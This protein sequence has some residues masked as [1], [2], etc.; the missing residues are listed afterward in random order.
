VG[1]AGTRQVLPMG[2]VIVRPGKVRLRVGDPIDTTGLKS[3]D[4]AELNRRL[5]DSIAELM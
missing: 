3:H 1:L 4:R 2:S 5:R